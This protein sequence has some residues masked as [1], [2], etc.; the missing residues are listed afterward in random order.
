MMIPLVTAR[1]LEIEALCKRLGVLRLELFGSATT[2]EFGPDS[3]LD[4]LVEFDLNEGSYAD[5][6][7]DLLESLQELLGRPVDLI[8]PSAVRNPYFKE[9]IDKTRSLLYAA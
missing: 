2:T 4:F 9:S 1:R 7:F 8:V 6:F 5:R 3:D